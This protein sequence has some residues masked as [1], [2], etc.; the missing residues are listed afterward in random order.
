MIQM[1][2]RGL[3]SCRRSN[4]DKIETLD[5]RLEEKVGKSLSG[6]PERPNLSCFS[7]FPVVEDIAFGEAESHIDP[8]NVNVPSEGVYP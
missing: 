1:L 7:S 3:L 2:F 8:P 4:A 6:F 5:V